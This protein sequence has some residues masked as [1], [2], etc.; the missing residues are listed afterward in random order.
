MDNGMAQQCVTYADEHLRDVRTTTG[1]LPDTSE[2]TVSE[3]LQYV[4]QQEP[5]TG[6]V[7][8]IRCT[9][10]PTTHASLTFNAKPERKH[11]VKVSRRSQHAGGGSA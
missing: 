5:L 10:N 9:E 11:F 7:A 1:F 2:A 3:F 6:Q 8:Q 4:M